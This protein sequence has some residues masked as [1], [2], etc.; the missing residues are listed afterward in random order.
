MKY[1]PKRCEGRK[2]LL[3][4]IPLSPMTPLRSEEKRCWAIP[5]SI[6]FEPNKRREGR[7]ISLCDDCFR[8]MRAQ[9]GEGFA[10]IVSLEEVQKAE[11]T[12]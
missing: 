1:D 6:A 9:I 11:A 10:E 8:G 5:T 3:L 7:A 4:S 2:R 12:K